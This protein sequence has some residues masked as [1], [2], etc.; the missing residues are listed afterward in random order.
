MAILIYFLII[1]I[2][3]LSYT[4]QNPDSVKTYN[5]TEIVKT[6][7]RTNTSTLELA[8][9]ISVIDS[10]EIIRRK[11]NT[12]LELLRTEYGIEITQQGGPGKFTNVYTRGSNPGHTL[13]L[14]DGI[15]MN[16]PNDPGSTFDFG[17]LQTDNIERIE[18]L[19]GPQSTLYG[20]DALA[21]V[22]NIITKKGTGKTN[23]YFSAE[24]G[25]Y[26]SIKTLAGI[27]GTI[28]IF[29]YSAS[30]SRLSTDGFSSAGKIYNNTEKDGHLNLLLTSKI[31]AKVTDFINLNLVL[32][33]TASQTE[34][35]QWGGWFGDDPTYIF[36][37]KETALRFEGNLDLFD[38]F[39]RQNAGISYLKNYRTYKFDS[40]LTN[41]VSSRS[42]YDGYK[43]KIDWLNNFFFDGNNIL[44]AGFESEEENANSE[45]IIYSSTYPLE[46]IFP[47]S[48]LRTSGIFLQG[49]TNFLNTFFITAGIRY[50]DHERF[51]G[52]ITYRLA[53][54]VIIWETGTKIKA[55]YGTGFKAP[56]LFYLF[57]PAF[58]NEKLLPEK[59][60]GWDAGIE[61]Y[62]WDEN[63]SLGVNYFDNQFKDLFGFDE[64]FRTININKA[65]TNGFEFFMDFLPA[66]N[67]KFNGNFTIT[68][69][70]DKSESSSDKDL[71]LIRRPLHKFSANVNYMFSEKANINIEII[72]T[73]KRYDKDFSKFPAERITLKPF[74]LINLAASYQLFD[75]LDLYSRIENILNEDYEEIFGYA[76]PQISVYFGINIKI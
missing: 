38:K 57:D 31:G 37:L 15:E 10:A 41:P 11:K 52:I 23:L 8:N 72:Y 70:K 71:P 69:S 14:I 48:K 50:D 42:F 35:D 68:R 20:S 7:T 2:A 60:I 76:T 46:S 59:S 62:F 63:L 18:I 58:G 12:V 36:D 49:Q 24:G 3:P 54:A 44:T 74:T 30:L 43:I 19:R 47:S 16:M 73:G 32:R 34:Y 6:A 53:P 9:S 26:N 65:E 56:S 27:D 5:F 33:H 61:Q 75:F 13:I 17:N 55:T 1:L 67:L 39:W 40:I 22:I 4:K 45:Y 21:G 66:D 28:D 64:N 25:S 51:D 29:D